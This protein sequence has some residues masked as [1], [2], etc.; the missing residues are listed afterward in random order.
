MTFTK[1]IKL[2]M[3]AMSFSYRLLLAFCF[4]S[5]FSCNKNERFLATNQFTSTIQIKSFTV[6]PTM[7]VNLIVDDSSWKKMEVANLT[8]L[9]TIYTQQFNMP[10]S[11]KVH[12]K[13][14]CND[15]SLIVD[16]LITLKSLNRF[17]LIQ[18]EKN[19]LPVFSTSFDDDNIVAADS[20]YINARFYLQLDSTDLS[21]LPSTLKLQF[22]K[23]VGTVD[24]HYEVKDTSIELSNG[25]LSSYI[26][27]PDCSLKE[28]GKDVWLGYKLIDPS[29]NTILQD[30]CY[31]NI[32]FSVAQI[33][34]NVGGE[35]QT[36]TF[37][38]L[39]SEPGC[40]FGSPAEIYKLKLL[41]GSK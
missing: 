8:Y 22:Y 36:F 41:F 38:Y 33:S 35:F 28:D 31:S 32:L 12:V 15:T 13:I 20:G 3:K 23:I 6:D 26:P 39:P 14:I 30:F 25:H 1:L 34:K 4:V 5:F 24:D 11:K 19:K 17:Y 40:D 7:T 21:P 29:T 2:S 18:F 27:L 9:Q 10:E 37:D 16:T